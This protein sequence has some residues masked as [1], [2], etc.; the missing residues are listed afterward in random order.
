MFRIVLPIGFSFGKYSRANRWL[1]NTA[2]GEVSRSRSSN[3]RPATIGMPI[4]SKN[5]V[6]TSLTQPMSSFG[7][8]GRS[9]MPT[10][11]VDPPP[12]RSGL[13][14]RLA[15]STPG[16]APIAASSR[17]KSAFLA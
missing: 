6:P 9:L 3:E 15:D 12:D 7:P 17:S 4:V 13:S 8:R 16:I 11:V 5:R 10:R 1:I 14:E 2:G